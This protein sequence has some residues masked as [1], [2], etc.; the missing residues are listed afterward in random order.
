MSRRSP[1]GA[2][3]SLEPWERAVQAAFLLSA[4]RGGFSVADLLLLRDLAAR[5]C[6]GSDGG[7][8]DGGR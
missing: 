5:F 6:P 8:V 1:S 3:F 4:G 2:P 7:S